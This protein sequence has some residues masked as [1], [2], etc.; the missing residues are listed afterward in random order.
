[1]T[2]RVAIS[3]LLQLVQGGALPS[4]PSLP[5]SFFIF[6]FIITFVVVWLEVS[7]VIITLTRFYSLSC[8]TYP[9]WNCNLNVLTSP[10]RR[11]RSLPSSPRWL[12][13]LSKFLDLIF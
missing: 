5:F 12:P 13:V 4:S 2:Q 8:M 10:S 1:M 11:S 3:L 7:L 9:A 6:Y